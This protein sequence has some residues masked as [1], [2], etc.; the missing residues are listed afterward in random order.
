[1]AAAVALVWSALWRAQVAHLAIFALVPAL[2]ALVQM[3]LG[4]LL[5][6]FLLVGFGDKEIGAGT[7]V[8]HRAS[9]GCWIVVMPCPVAERTVAHLPMLR[10][11][12]QA[13]PSTEP[14]LPRPSDLT[15]RHI[16]FVLW[17]VWFLVFLVRR[18]RGRR[19]G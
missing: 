18:E 6:P 3:T 12:P 1:M 4:V 16:W 19:V 5:F 14:F 13:E 17:L 11:E 15:L 2:A 9:P 7:Q 8:S 10:E